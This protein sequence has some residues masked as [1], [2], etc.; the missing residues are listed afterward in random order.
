LSRSNRL[1][2]LRFNSAF[3]LI[4]PLVVANALA[5][6]MKVESN[7]QSDR[8]TR[9]EFKAS[10]SFLA[11][12]NNEQ[13]CNA[14]E[15]WVSSM[16][17]EF[18]QPR[19]VGDRVH[20]GEVDLNRLNNRQLFALGTPAFGAVFGR[21]LPELTPDQ[22]QTI[23]KSLSKCSE[24][25]YVPSNLVMLFDSPQALEPWIANFDSWERSLRD[26]RLAVLRAA[27]LEQNMSRYQTELK[28]TGIPA[29]ELIK[30][31][32]LYRLNGNLT[33]RGSDWCDF[34]N[35]Q[36]LVSLVFKADQNFQ[37]DNSAAYWGIFESEMLTIFTSPILL[38]V[39]CLFTTRTCLLNPETG[40]SNLRV[41]TRL[42][43]RFTRATQRVG[44][45]ADGST[46][47]TVKQH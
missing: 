37:I 13:R 18:E 47:R 1:L 7:V 40:P 28:R 42:V 8:P 33:R 31:S 15:V 2:F 46:G 39:R 24:K 26:I 36:A 4:F 11:A 5:A 45:G 22:L 30:D 43:L 27:D 17:Y 14:I 21:R 41:V 23:G 19:Y 44:R 16:R 6:P 34:S 38:R 12:R 9:K 35:H 32:S 3:A 10:P 20:S 29:A 25:H